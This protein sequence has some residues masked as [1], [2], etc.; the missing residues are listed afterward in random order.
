MPTKPLRDISGR[1]IPAPATK[2]AVEHV[3]AVPPVRNVPNEQAIEFIVSGFTTLAIGAV[4]FGTLTDPQTS[5]AFAVK[6]PDNF[7]GRIDSIFVFCPDMV[8]ATAPYLFWQLLINAQPAN[9]WSSVPVYPRAGVASLTFD[10]VVDLPAN[11]LLQL[12]AKNTDAANT[13]FIAIYLHGWYWGVDVVQ[14]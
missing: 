12:F 9:A 1:V 7:V 6:L 3:L 5:A 8:P 14:G 4:T 2:S 11:A 10:A 13:H